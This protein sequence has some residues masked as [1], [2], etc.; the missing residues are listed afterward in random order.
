MSN[1]RIWRKH[2]EMVSRARHENKTEA[3]QNEWV[4]SDCGAPIKFVKT[5]FL[6]YVKPKC[7]VCGSGNATV[8]SGAFEDDEK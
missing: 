7:T 5:G 1:H 6:D 2:R 4:C 8:V 3:L